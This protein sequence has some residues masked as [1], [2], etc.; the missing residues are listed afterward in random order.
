MYDGFYGDISSFY[1]N[2]DIAKNGPFTMGYSAY[3]WNPKAYHPMADS[4][5]IT[6]LLYGKKM[7]DI[8]RPG[9]LAL[10]YFDK[11]DNKFQMWPA[12]YAER[13]LVKT[14]YAIVQE[15]WD[16][17]VGYNPTAIRHMPTWYGDMVW[18]AG[19][20]ARA[21]DTAKPWEERMAVDIAELREIAQK[22]VALNEA[23]GDRFMPGICFIGGKQRSYGFRTAEEKAQNPSFPLGIRKGVFLEKQMTPHAR[24]YSD[25][26]AEPGRD[27]ELIL[28]GMHE[29]NPDDLDAPMCRIRVNGY[30]VFAGPTLLPPCDWGTQKIAIPAR[31]LNPDGTNRLEIVNLE[32]GYGTQTPPFIAIVYAV[33]R[34]PA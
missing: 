7:W 24:A 6:A 17:A 9:N 10:A 1:Y 25:F 8:I 16:K 28:R 15:A 23:K 33:I 30:T 4:K 22:E 11:F 26:K 19:E 29:K 5:R 34:K 3:M 14:N 2:Q 32:E 20:L 31:I 13:D 12:A 27:R 21:I 18:W